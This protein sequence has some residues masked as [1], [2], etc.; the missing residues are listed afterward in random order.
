[1]DLAGTQGKSD[2][3]TWPLENK[4]ALKAIGLLSRSVRGAKDGK[5]ELSNLVATK[6]FDSEFERT[7]VPYSMQSG[8]AP[9]FHN[10]SAML[11]QW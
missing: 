3:D 9:L 7:T 5:V 6:G 1:M 8:F 4:A 11:T 10:G 2:K